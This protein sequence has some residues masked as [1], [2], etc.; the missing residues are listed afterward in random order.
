MT[1]LP[2]LPGWDGFHPL[3]VH[4]PIALLMVAPL[5]VILALVGRSSPTGRAM[6]GAALILM[7]LGTL[8]T[9][10]ASSTGSAAA[11]VVAHTPPVSAV[12]DRH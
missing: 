12:L 9:F 2:P 1:G 11:R 5:F 4:F 8:G 6:A 3:M 7:S 10:L